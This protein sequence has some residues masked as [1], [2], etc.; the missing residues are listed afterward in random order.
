MNKRTASNA[1][2]K[3]AKIAFQQNG[4]HKTTVEDIFQQAN[5]SIEEFD[6]A[7]GS[8]EK[9][10]LKVLKAYTADMKKKLA[11]YEENMN[12][13]QRLS[14]YLDDFFDNADDIAEN[15]SAMFNL[16]CAL[17]NM[18]T[19]LSDAAEGLLNLQKNWIDE[20]FVN[21]L[22]TQSAVDQGDRLMA[23]LHGLFFLACLKNDAAMF[24]SQI[25]Q[26][27]SWIRSM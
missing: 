18:D 4:Y 13:R 16:Y 14:L 11:E 5:L 27:K 25:I 12:S 8:K 23:A 19:D 6:D 22:K 2:V 26:L 20:Q 3:A 10:C 7:I 17:R 15:G 21:M 24:K 1:I 9:C